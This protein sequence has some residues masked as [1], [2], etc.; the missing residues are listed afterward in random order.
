MYLA[1]LCGEMI[2]HY[3]T[4][5]P[6]FL[7]LLLCSTFWLLP[8]LRIPSCRSVNIYLNLVSMASG[9]L[10]TPII[11]SA[12]TMKHIFQKVRVVQHCIY[13]ECF[14]TYFLFVFFNLQGHVSKTILIPQGQQL[15]IL[16]W[17]MR[18]SHS[19]RI[20][21]TR[22]CSTFTVAER[23]GCVHLQNLHC[24]VPRK[25]GHSQ[26]QDFRCCSSTN[27]NYKRVDRYRHIWT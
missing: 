8:F 2:Y 5:F 12:K 16:Q 3:P 22:H 23:W 9:R 19:H 17:H 1:G 25:L 14:W 6:S 13:N 24:T 4:S 20:T 21:G 26:H 10:F 27:T 11:E 15:C 18:L 7:S